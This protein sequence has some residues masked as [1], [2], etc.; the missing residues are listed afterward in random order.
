MDFGA[1]K[2]VITSLLKRNISVIKVPAQTSAEKILEYKPD[3]IMLSSGP[4]DPRENEEII[5]EVI[6]LGYDASIYDEKLLK[7]G[8]PQPNLLKK[9]FF[10]SL[11]FLL[12]LMYFS[13]GGMLNL[14]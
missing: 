5:K 9:R 11:W 1:K 10:I 7:E 6:N 12:P 8:K 2:S 13:M 4:G 3:G 14:P